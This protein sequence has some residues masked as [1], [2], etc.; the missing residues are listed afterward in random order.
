MGLAMSSRQLLFASI[1]IFIILLF[2]PIEEDLRD[3][4][5]PIYLASPITMTV[6]R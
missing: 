3:D 2:A 4:R 5:E 6:S 1:I